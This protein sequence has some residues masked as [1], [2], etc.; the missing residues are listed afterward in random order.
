[1]PARPPASSDAGLHVSVDIE[2]TPD[3]PKR[4]AQD[5]DDL[6][7]KTLAIQRARIGR[8]PTLGF[9]LVPLFRLL[10]YD[11]VATVVG[12]ALAGQKILFVS[13]EISSL[14]RTVS[15]AASIGVFVCRICLNSFFVYF[16][17]LCP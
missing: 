17:M 2:L 9:S 8:L 14:T 16:H 4:P 15:L 7:P 10:D 3:R 11:N 5:D 12:A 13:R 1:M 6:P